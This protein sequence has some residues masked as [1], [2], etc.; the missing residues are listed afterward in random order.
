MARTV[1]ILNGASLSGDLDMG[2]ESKLTGVIMPAAWTAASLT[3][4]GS[5]DGVAFANVYDDGGT[6]LSLTVAA[7]RSVG[8]RRDARLAIAPWRYLRIR[9]GAAGAPVAQGA[10]RVIEIISR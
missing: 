6:E 4:Q 1:T 7:S 8:L 3:F 10:D 2:P 9:S 5:N